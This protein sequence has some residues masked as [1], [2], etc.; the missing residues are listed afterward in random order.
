MTHELRI[1]ARALDEAWAYCV[2]GDWCIYVGGRVRSG[3]N[4][5]D[6]YQKHLREKETPDK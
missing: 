5:V 2:G 4:I 1:T 6:E 3:K